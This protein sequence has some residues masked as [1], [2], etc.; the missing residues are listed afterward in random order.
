MG[1]EAEGDIEQDLAGEHLSLSFGR[2]RNKRTKS[3][4]AGSMSAARGE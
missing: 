4:M 3:D 2:Q 1:D